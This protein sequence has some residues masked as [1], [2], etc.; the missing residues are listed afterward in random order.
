MGAA[1][2]FYGAFGALH[3]GVTLDW[4][5][6]LGALALMLSSPKKPSQDVALAA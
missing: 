2:L 6:F 1:G 4:V 3:L 5:L